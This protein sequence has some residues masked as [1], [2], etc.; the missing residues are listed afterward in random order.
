MRRKRYRSVPGV[1][2]FLGAWGMERAKIFSETFRSGK[3]SHLYE[4]F[5][6]NFCIARVDV[7]QIVFMYG[8]YACELNPCVLI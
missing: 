4:H 5:H 3:L 1:S 6:L 8:I 2:S 7:Q